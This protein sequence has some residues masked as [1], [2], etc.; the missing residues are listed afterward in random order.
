MGDKKTFV[1]PSLLFAIL[2]SLI[3][4][5]GYFQIRII[6]KN[7]EALLKN[8][9]EIIFNHLK[10]EIDINLE[11]L[12]LLEKSPSI[13]TPNF[14]NIMVYDEA[15]IDDLYNFF[16]NIESM[17][18]EK[19]PI[20]N[21]IVIDRDG[22]TITKKGLVRVPMSYIRTF[23]SGEKETFVKTPG[24]G[25]KFFTM[26]IKTKGNAVF[27]SLDEDELDALRKKLT[28][29]EIVEAEEKRFNIDGINIYDAK[30]IPYISSNGNREEAY[31]VSMPLD[32]KYLPKFIVEILVSKGL[33]RD[34]L[35][36]TTMNFLF[37]LVLLAISGAVSTYAIFLLERRHAKRLR[38]FEKELEMKE[39]LVSLGKLS[40]GMAHEIRNPLNAMSMSIQ[41][42]KREFTPAKEKEEEYYQFIDIIRN[43][44]SRIDRIVEEFLL[45][46][47]SHAPFLQENLDNVIEEVVVILREKAASKGID[48][49]IS[50]ADNDIMIQ[51]QKERLKQAFYNIVLNGIEAINNGGSIKITTS[52]KD[53]NIDISIKDTGAGIN[54]KELH[55]IFEYYYTTKD[56]GIGLG[57]P[58]SYMIIKDHGGDISAF[59]EQGKGTTFV[60]TMPMNQPPAEG[61]K[62]RE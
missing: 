19:M 12:N 49:I 40:S 38:E 50:K 57:L 7:I 51:S 11:Y 60:I 44:L 21:I 62:T 32:S 41:R 13:I 22:K 55:R 47:K 17:D 34:I 37:I 16:R 6:K 43:E 48:I 53:G 36:R 59:S 45:S 26:G 15:I 14:L 9:G 3:T 1:F 31:V 33:A 52:V 46:T 35:K 8:E 25:D 24:K 56:K 39:R 18:V 20:S 54:E 58:I 2:F 42:L 23:Q 29:K 61:Q 30:G 28:L 4:I 27:F 5:T 10:R